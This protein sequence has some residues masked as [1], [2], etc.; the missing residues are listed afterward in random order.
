[1][2]FSE[3]IRLIKLSI[4]REITDTSEQAPLLLLFY[5]IPE[6]AS[7]PSGSLPQDE[8]SL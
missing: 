5:D 1:M 4:L 8:D 2:K 3:M 7:E 6:D